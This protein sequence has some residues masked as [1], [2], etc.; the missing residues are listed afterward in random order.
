MCPTRRPTRRTRRRRRGA[1]AGQGRARQASEARTA[2]D[3][4]SADD[5]PPRR[6]RTTGGPKA[7]P[8][9]PLESLE[10]TRNM[11]SRRRTACVT[12]DGQ[13]PL[14]AYGFTKD[15][16]QGSGGYAQLIPLLL[17]AALHCHV[18]QGKELIEREV[19]LSSRVTAESWSRHRTPIRAV[20]APAAS[21]GVTGHPDPRLSHSTRGPTRAQRAAR[22]R[23]RLRQPCNSSTGTTTQGGPQP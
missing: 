3:T 21:P 14:M 18:R 22:E 12:T 13:K 17:W 7:P 5:V 19:R 16:A 15:A 11:R 23:S 2:T 9:S 4:S 6:R 20:P 10:K 8:A 1:V